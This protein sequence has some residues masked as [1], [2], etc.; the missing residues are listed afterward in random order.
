MNQ[1]VVSVWRKPLPLFIRVVG[2]LVIVY[3]LLMFVGIIGGFIMVTWVMPYWETRPDFTGQRISEK[4]L[5]IFYICIFIDAVWNTLVLFAGLRMFLAV[6]EKAL[7]EFSALT[8][9]LVAIFVGFL[10]SEILGHVFL[11]SLIALVGAVAAYFSVRFNLYS[12]LKRI[13]IKDNLFNSGDFVFNQ[14]EEPRFVSL[15]IDAESQ[16]RA[17]V[18]KI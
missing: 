6:N 1:E 17:N 2:L 11:P 15:I 4:F 8:A 16:V 3:T 12:L 7:A 10:L 18:L 14:M 9:W 5:V 13:L